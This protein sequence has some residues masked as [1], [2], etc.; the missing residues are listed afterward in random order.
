MDKFIKRLGKVLYNLDNSIGRFF[1]SKRT[2]NSKVI[3]FLMT[4]L[5]IIAASLLFFIKEDYRLKFFITYIIGAFI[6]FV[7]V[8]AWYEFKKLK[9]IDFYLFKFNKIDFNKVDFAKLQFSEDE[10]ESFKTLMQ[11]QKL[12]DKINFRLSA[13]S[14]KSANYRLLFAMFDIL[15]EGDIKKFGKEQKEDFFLMLEESF[16]MNNKDVNK[17]TL[18]T[19]FSTW[20]SELNKEKRLEGGKFMESVL[21]IE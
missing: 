9:N 21:G 13:K 15:I 2:T 6:L 20:K 19:S 7:A 11:H 16:S 10:K 18:K 5:A 4:F 3:L 1:K 14:N 17:Q 8:G 12:T